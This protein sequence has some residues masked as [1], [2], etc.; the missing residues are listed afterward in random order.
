LRSCDRSRDLEKGTLYYVF[1]ASLVVH[2]S[3][4]PSPIALGG[5][6]WLCHS[7]DKHSVL[8]VPRST[9]YNARLIHILHYRIDDRFHSRLARVSLTSHYPIIPSRSHSPTYSGYP[10]HSPLLYTCNGLCHSVGVLPNCNLPSVPVS[11]ARCAQV[12][13]YS[14]FSVFARALFF[15]AALFA[16]VFFF[17]RLTSAG[18]SALNSHLTSRAKYNF[19]RSFALLPLLSVTMSD[20]VLTTSSHHYASPHA[21]P[22]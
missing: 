3:P 2:P 20:D 5:R 16:G 19:L 6:L 22:V 7:F 18:E 11:C 1:N 17:A 12:Y 4:S 15:D 9:S 10:T 14:I 8:N 13:T 21:Y